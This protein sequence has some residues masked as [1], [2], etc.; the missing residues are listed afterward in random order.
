MTHP[1]NNNYGQRE[2]CSESSAIHGMKIEI[3]P[4][5]LAPNHRRAYA[6]AYRAA[7]RKRPLRFVSPIVRFSIE[8][9]W[10]DG[11]QAYWEDADRDAAETLAEEA[12]AAH[13]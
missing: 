8:R 2:S 7:Y 10:N 12:A 9:G 5:I 1:S 6:M 11:E 13:A 4:D 3:P